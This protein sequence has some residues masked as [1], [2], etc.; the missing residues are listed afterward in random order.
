MSKDPCALKG[1]LTK[2]E[3]VAEEHSFLCAKDHRSNDTL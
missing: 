2:T 3:H 1:V